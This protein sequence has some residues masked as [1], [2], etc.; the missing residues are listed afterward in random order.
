MIS[1]TLADL[2]ILFVGFQINIL[3]YKNKVTRSGVTNIILII[4]LILFVL[5]FITSFEVV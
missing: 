1:K 2:N 3:E 5:G 4:V